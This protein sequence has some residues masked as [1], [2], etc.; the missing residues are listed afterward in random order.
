MKL[1]ISSSSF[2]TKISNQFVSTDPT[3]ND[4]YVWTKLHIAVLHLVKTGNALLLETGQ[5][6]QQYLKEP[7]QA[8][9]IMHCSNNVG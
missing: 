2:V 9:A 3:L 7:V 8:Y 6:E 4:H 5:T 1:S